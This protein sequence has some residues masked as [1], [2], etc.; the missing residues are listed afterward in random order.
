LEYCV[1]FLVVGN[2]SLLPL[3]AVDYFDELDENARVL[4]ASKKL[5]LQQAN[6]PYLLLVR[7]KFLKDDALEP[8]QL[9]EWLVTHLFSK[10]KTAKPTASD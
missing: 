10:F 1:S 4:C 7:Q 5:L 6:V 9:R 8:A 3:V 2:K